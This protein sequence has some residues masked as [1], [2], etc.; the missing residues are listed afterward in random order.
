VVCIGIPRFAL[1]KT[2][3]KDREKELVHYSGWK[4]RRDGGDDE[5]KDTLNLN[6]A[7]AETW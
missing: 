4:Q 6:I 5:W 1:E 7:R 3:N 2:E